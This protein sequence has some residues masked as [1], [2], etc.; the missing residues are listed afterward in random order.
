MAYLLKRE[1]ED[2]IKKAPPGT[3]PEGV[4][5]ALREQ[6]HQLEGYAAPVANKVDDPDERNLLER[7]VYGLADFT[8]VTALGKGAAAAINAPRNNKLREQSMAQTEETRSQLITQI[9]KSKAEGKDTLRLERALAQLNEASG[10]TVADFNAMDDLGV[11]NRDVIGSAVRTAGTI[12]SFGSYGSAAAGAQTGARLRNVP[13]AVTKI[14]QATTAV[15]G[16]IEGA[17]VGAKVGAKSGTIFGALQS[18]GLGIQDEEAGVGEVLAKTAGGA[19]VGGLTG[20]LVGGAIGAASGAIQARA[21]FRTQLEEKIGGSNAPYVERIKIAAKETADELGTDTKAVKLI[22]ARNAVK[23]SEALPIDEAIAAGDIT[24][25]QIYSD[26]T[27]KILQPDFAKGRVQDVQL[28]LNAAQPG[29]GD[30]FVKTID[31][32]N[33]TYD[34]IVNKGLTKLDEVEQ[35]VR[36]VQRAGTP[37]AETALFKRD[38]KTGK[39][40]EDIDAK[41]L[42]RATGLEDGDIAMMKSGTAKDRLAYK[43]MLDAADEIRNNPAAAV[44]K[45]PSAIAGKNGYKLIKAIQVEKNEAGR[46]IGQLV[47][48]DLASKNV[49]TQPVYERWVADLAED[50]VT[51]AD[52]GKL[53]FSGSRYEDVTGAQ[54][55]IEKAHKKAL[56]LKTS[57]NAVKAHNFKGQLDE[58][59][60]FGNNADGVSGSASRLVKGLRHGIDAQLDSSF[61]VYKTANERYAK[62]TGALKRIE[63]II[64]KKTMQADDVV[65]ERKVGQIL[66]R[67]FSNSE[68]TALDLTTTLDD[69][70]AQLGL[71]TDDTITNQAYFARVLEDIYGAPK[72]S[73]AGRVAQGT[74][75][76]VQKYQGLRRLANAPIDTVANTALDV[77]D[78][79]NIEKAEALRKYVE[80]LLPKN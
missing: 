45:K 24:P 42:M 41:K 52:D 28:K 43:E 21:N 49:K 46:N 67:L 57:T 31:V 69:A 27:K 66:Q 56:Q 60:D 71:L 55:L 47:R 23:S 30:D 29:L 63:S 11:T 22:K 61:S 8:G 53:V 62:S 70:A 2:I 39:I 37:S 12:A 10:Q 20:G 48:K 1:V 78:S 6:G 26:Q 54:G 18:L 68:S 17:K 7:A 16:A 59:V 65:V 64:G 51:I 35:G 38:P 32:N 75:Q 34:E 4:V 15:R 74:G 77:F 58:L 19:A 25:E 40:I 33:T 14:T 80:Q 79:A 9:K 50:G 3:T 44:T 13:G 5:A 73:M 72:N 36:T 76:T